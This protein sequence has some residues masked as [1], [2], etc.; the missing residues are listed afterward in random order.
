MVGAPAA[1]C[2]RQRPR[3][4]REASLLESEAR[5]RQMADHIQEIFWMIDA[6]TKK[7]LYVNR[8]YETITGRSREALQRKP[9][10]LCR[11]D[12]PTGSPPD[13]GQARRS[14]P[15]G[16]IQRTISDCVTG[17]DSRWIWV[18]GFPVRDGRGR[19]QKLVRTAKDVTA[20]KQAQEE[21]DRNLIMAE[22]AWAEVD[23]L[24]KAT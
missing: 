5:F 14:D 2:D 18:G 3:R 4:K 19:I 1:A 17:R 16:E 13:I 7:A 10:L 11:A 15:H 24:R 8:A 22:A 20:Q 21:I 23:A 9:A 6:H 12:P